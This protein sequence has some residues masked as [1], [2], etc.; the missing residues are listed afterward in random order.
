VHFN[1][2]S[3]Y[4][5]FYSCSY[6]Y[7]QGGTATSASSITA[8]MSAIGDAF[9]A[10]RDAMIAAAAGAEKRTSAT[11]S[12]VTYGVS[13]SFG[14]QIGEFTVA[15]TH[16]GAWVLDAFYLGLPSPLCSELAEC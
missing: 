14:N 3:H 10:E 6:V 15:Q 2:Q 4:H 9:E 13:D 12:V 8:R 5:Y 1:D 7:Q 16:D 11:S